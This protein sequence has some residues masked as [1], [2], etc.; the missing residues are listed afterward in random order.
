[1]QFH[2]LVLFRGYPPHFKQQESPF[3]SPFAKPFR[4]STV[5]AFPAIRCFPFLAVGHAPFYRQRKRSLGSARDDDTGRTRFPH[6]LCM[7]HGV[8]ILHTIISSVARNGNT[9]RTFSQRTLYTIQR[10]F[11]PLHCHFE[12]SEK[13][14]SS[15]FSHNSFAKPFTGSTAYR[16]SAIRRFPFPAAKHSPSCRQR[17]RSL[18][19]ARD[20]DTGNVLSSFLLP[21]IGYSSRRPSF[22]AQREIFFV[23]FFPRLLR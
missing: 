6:I 3:P 5:P 11:I 18:G 23:P 17:K 15:P 2:I 22:R 21:C 12:R 1:M 10:I 4:G 20:D 19:F 13:S 16:L 9:G 7:M 14:L 8:F